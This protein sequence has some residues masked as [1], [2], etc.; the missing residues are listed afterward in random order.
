MIVQIANTIEIVC[1]YVKEA[2]NAVRNS[3]FEA[4]PGAGEEQ[5]TT[6][7]QEKLQIVLSA[8]SQQGEIAKA[9]AVDLEGAGVPKDDGG[10]VQMACGIIAEVSWHPRHVERKTGGDFGL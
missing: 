2:E 6:L 8:A 10:S 1:K 7:F 3:V 9:F 4:F 5:I